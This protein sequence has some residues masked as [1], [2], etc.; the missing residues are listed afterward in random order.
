[1]CDKKRLAKNVWRK[2]AKKTAWQKRSS[3]NRA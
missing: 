1:M 2:S 3:K